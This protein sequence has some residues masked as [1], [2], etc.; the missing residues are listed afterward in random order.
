MARTIVITGAGEGLGK[1]L[2]RRFTAE[3]DTVVLLGRTLAKLETAA[4]EFGDN[5]L[6]V[7]CD[8][9]NPDSVREAFAAIAKAHAQIDVLIN[10]AAVYAPFTLAEAS[11]EQ[12]MAQITTN[13]AGPIFVTR[14]AAKMMGPGGHIINVTSEGVEVK[15]PMLWCYAGTKAALERIGQGWADELRGAG[16]RV[17]TI[18]AGKM[19]GEGKTSS[20][21]DMELTMRFATACAEAG[22]PL[23]EQPLSNYDSVLDIFR[24]V[25]ES[26]PDLN[27]DLV[28]LG[29]RRA[30]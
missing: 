21:W 2:A 10:N 22:M 14:E 20:G 9:G 7:Q 18:R 13:I 26:A 12:V 24:T 23:F 1:A 27:L 30:S 5:C 29:G 25:I 4:A 19:F 8:V 15:M 17:T 16:I 11:D 28:T 3:G 6:P